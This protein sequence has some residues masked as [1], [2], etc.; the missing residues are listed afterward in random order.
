LSADTRLSQASANRANAR[1]STGPKTTAGNARAGRNALRHGL[2]ISLLSDAA[3]APEVE[4][5]ARRIAGDGADIQS[6]S[7]ADAIAEPQIELLRMR[8]HRRRLIEL[9]FADPT[10]GTSDQPR[11]NLR[12]EILN[13]IAR[14]LAAVDRYERRATSR[15]KS[16]IRR[17]DALSRVESSNDVYGGA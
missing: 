1:R 11:L 8:A 2:H 10:L 12:V 5:L 13:A 17:F 7:L 9:A 3:W 16:A 4:A 14:E 6:L 15:R